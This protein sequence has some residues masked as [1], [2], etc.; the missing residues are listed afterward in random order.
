ML[1]GFPVGRTELETPSRGQVEDALET[2]TRLSLATGWAGPL[3]NRGVDRP[4]PGHPDEPAWLVHEARRYHVAD[5]QVPR[6]LALRVLARAEDPCAV[7]EALGVEWPT[8]V[9]DDAELVALGS[10]AY[11]ALVAR[12]EAAA[13]EKSPA[14]ASS[15]AAALLELDPGHLPALAATF[16]GE[17]HEEAPSAAHEVALRHLVSVLAAEEGGSV[18]PALAELEETSR[19][20][21]AALAARLTLALRYL[22]ADMPGSASTLLASAA[23]SGPHGNLADGLA[24]A[25]RAEV[26]WLVGGGSES[27]L[28][29]S[30]P[31]LTRLHHRLSQGSRAPHMEKA[32]AAAETR[33]VR[34][35]EGSV[36]WGEIQGIA[37]KL[38]ED[39]ETPAET[40][41]RTIDLLRNNDD[42]V[43]GGLR[44]CLREGLDTDR[45][46][47]LVGHVEAVFGRNDGDGEDPTAEA[48]LATRESRASSSKLNEATGEMTRRELLKLRR[49]LKGGRPPGLVDTGER[50]DATLRLATATGRAGEVRRFLEERRRHPRPLTALAEIIAAGLEDRSLRAEDAL[51]MWR[52]VHGLGAP[53]PTSLGHLAKKPGE[54]DPSW[55]AETCPGRRELRRDHV[56]AGGEGDELCLRPDRP[57]YLAQP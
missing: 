44:H 51:R 1:A 29:L 34:F 28:A 45:C 49:L 57:G 25:L 46:K 36:P 47:L 27:E 37:R 50:A 48:W 26:E 42:Y 7:I 2:A 39:A 4:A 12:L 53:D 32:R 8:G 18:E 52:D 10:C 20:A 15:A 11:A 5:S 33:L 41:R 9:L 31:W 55:L 35:P 30:S 21:P 17:E 16:V 23:A 56:G 43:W 22:A 13:T 38:G 24:T 54:E 40:R 14:R 3:W 19:D 6:E